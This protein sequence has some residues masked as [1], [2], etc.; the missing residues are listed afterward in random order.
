M[1]TLLR[2]DTIYTLAEAKEAMAA[3][4]RQLPAQA[5]S[6]SPTLKVFRREFSIEPINILFWLHNQ[7]ADTKIYWSDRDSQFEIG[8]IGIADQ[9]KGKGVI[10]HK[11]VFDHISTHLSAD[12]PQLRY[13]GGMSFDPSCQDSEWKKFG[14]YQFIIPQ[15]E[16][17]H[18]NGQTTFALNITVDTINSGHIEN[19]ITQLN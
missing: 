9:I 11:K 17:I 5:P 8:A 3:Y 19:I 15:F 10:D 4:I 1:A 18:L 16:I 7:K 6:I 2:P 12:N 14:T 13:Y